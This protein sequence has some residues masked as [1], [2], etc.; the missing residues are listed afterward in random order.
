MWSIC[1]LLLVSQFVPVTSETAE[2]VRGRVSEAEPE[3]RPVGGRALQEGSVVMQWTLRNP[4]D[5]HR[6][7]TRGERAHREN[8]DIR[9]VNRG[10]P[11]AAAQYFA[12]GER[13]SA[14]DR[15]E[16]RG[17]GERATFASTASDDSSSHVSFLSGTYVVYVSAPT[18]SIARRVARVVEGALAAP[19][20]S[21]PVVRTM[22]ADLESRTRAAMED[23]TDLEFLYSVLW[24]KGRDVMSEWR[25]RQPAAGSD[26]NGRTLIVRT[27]DHRAVEKAKAEFERARAGVAGATVPAGLG[28]DALMTRKGER[29]DID[30]IVRAGRYLVVVRGPSELLA[31]K[32]A[33]VVRMAIGG[34]AM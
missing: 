15:G 22:P 26:D 8:V 27:L 19:Q 3:F 28:H 23:A 34:G 1:L 24:A 9:L 14:V 31:Q 33:S 2:R 11:E 12:D 18:G 13:L 20:P 32:A 21:R 6:G 10:S 7:F 16:L 17:I 5:A 30:V 29:G 4:P 25:V